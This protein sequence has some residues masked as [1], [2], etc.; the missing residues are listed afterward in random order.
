MVAIN[1]ITDCIVAPSLFGGL[2]TTMLEAM[3]LGRPVI[4]SSVGGIP[5]VIKDKIN[6][7]LFKPK[8]PNML[9]D[10]IIEL[11]DSEDLRMKLGLNARET[12]KEKY[13]INVVV[14]DIERLYLSLAR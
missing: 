13:D 8:D 9:A 2:S 5:E 11:M 10:K 1:L 14:K 12:V 7:I 3:A 6:G 4:A